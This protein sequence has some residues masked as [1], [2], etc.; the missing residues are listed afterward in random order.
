MVEEKYTV[1]YSRVSTNDQKE[2]LKRQTEELEEYCKDNQI[3][4]VIGIKEGKA[5]CGL[6]PMFKG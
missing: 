2:D 5:K 6:P 1:C 4:K 3:D